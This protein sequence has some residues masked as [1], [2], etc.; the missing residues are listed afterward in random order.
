MS[1]T[2]CW[3]ISIWRWW[4]SVSLIMFNLE[5]FDYYSSPLSSSFVVK[6]IFFFKKHK[7]H[8]LYLLMQPGTSKNQIKLALSYKTIKTALSATI[9]LKFTQP[10][11]SKPTFLGTSTTQKFLMFWFRALIS[12]RTRVLDCFDSEQK[13]ADAFST[14]HFLVLSCTLEL[15]CAILSYLA[16]SWA[17]LRNILPILD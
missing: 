11:A 9:F 8:I 6:N 13:S 12:W 16:L 15:S 2:R 10:L 1:W 4:V 17:I 14:F 7:I 3:N 5:N